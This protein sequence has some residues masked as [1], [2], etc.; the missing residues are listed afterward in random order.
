MGDSRYTPNITILR[1][2]AY[3]VM[4]GVWYIMVMLGMAHIHDGY[5]MYT[6]RYVRVIPCILTICMYVLLPPYVHG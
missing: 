1:V 5:R 3:R 2:C 4:E 6:T